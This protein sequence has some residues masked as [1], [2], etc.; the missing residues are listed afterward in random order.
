MKLTLPISCSSGAL[1]VGPFYVIGSKFLV[2]YCLLT[3]CLLV[4]LQLWPDLQLFLFYFIVV[5]RS[6]YFVYALG[7]L[8]NF[9]YLS[10][11]VLDKGGE[12]CEFPRPT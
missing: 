8:F 7:Y 9:L 4:D 3:I 11:D 2:T 10:N 1:W 6:V 12:F 5:H